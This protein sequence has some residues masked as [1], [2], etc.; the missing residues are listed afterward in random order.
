MV[1]KESLSFALSYEELLVLLHHFKMSEME[2]VDTT[3][4]A[5]LSEKER[6]LVM[7]SAERALVARGYLVRGSEKKVKLI[8]PVLALVGT[9]LQPDKSLIIKFTEAKGF[10]QTFFFHTAR[11]MRVIHT[12][13]IVGIHQFIAVEDD[14]SLLQAIISSAQLNGLERLKCDNGVLDISVL[15]NGR[16]IAGDKGPELAERLFIEHKFPKK[17]AQAL[18]RSLAEPISNTTISF[19]D[20]Q[21]DYVEG[22]TVLKSHDALWLMSPN[23]DNDQISIESISSKDVIQKL[24]SLI[25]NSKN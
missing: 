18:A 11:K 21:R 13:P 12:I 7:A 1:K 17:S 25:V 20:T 14:K 16:D 23:E 2:G 5:D 10:E 8:E 19:I 15:N 4:L 24:K 3:L 9:C 6:N 22:S